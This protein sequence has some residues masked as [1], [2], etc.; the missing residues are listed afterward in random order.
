M[1]LPR[2]VCVGLLLSIASAALAA[3]PEKAVR[4]ALDP[5]VVSAAERAGEFLRE[6]DRFSFTAQTAYEVVQSDGSKLEFGATRRY[7]VNRPD[8]IRVEV[9]P[10][11]GE[12]RLIVFDGDR[13]TFAEPDAK[14]YA[15]LRLKQHRGIDEMV[16]LLR[17]V[18]DVRRLRRDDTGHRLCDVGG[19]GGRGRVLPVRRGLVHTRRRR[20]SSQL[21]GRAA[22]ARPLMDEA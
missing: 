21:R 19:R 3:A 4:P 16:V 10:R 12:R 2:P 9:E 8:R 18:L 22:T 13:L 14:I 15:Q 1:S 7:L 6:R 17:D 5:Q 20:R 11:S